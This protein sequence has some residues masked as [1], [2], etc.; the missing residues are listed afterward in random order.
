MT[1]RLFRTKNLDTLLES[2][3]EPEHQLRRSLGVVSLTALGIGAIIG[4][5]IFATTGSAAAGSAD[6]PGAGPAIIVS[7][8]VT[9]VACGFAALCYAEFASMLPISGSAYTYSYA[10]FGEL[11]AWVIGWDLILEYAVGNIAVAVS[12]SGY[13]DSLLSGLGVHLPP[14]AI[15]N[16]NTM[17]GAAA[18]G[19][20]KTP[21]MI[22]AARAAIDAA[23]HLLG[24]PVIVNIPAVVIVALITVVLVVG[25][26]ESAALNSTIVVLKI[27]VLI[28]FVV[29]GISYVDPGNW[30]PFAPNGWHGI[31]TGAA[32]VF[33]AYI[34]FDAVSTTAEEARNPQRDLPRSMMWSLAICTV[35]YIGIALVLTG[36]VPSS[37]LNVAD[38]LAFALHA[39]NL[40]WASGIIAFGAVISM[41]AVLLVFQLGQPRIFFSMSR[42]GLLPPAFSKVHPRF[43]TPHIPTILTGVFVAVP[44]A[45]LDINS[46]VEFTNIGTLFAFILVC[47]GVIILRRT[48]PDRQRRFRTPWVPLVPVLGILS[49]L[50]LMISLPGVTWLRFLIWLF[51]GANIYFLYGIDHS[52]LS[53][54]GT[55]GPD[56]SVRLIRW[57]VVVLDAAMLVFLFVILRSGNPTLATVF[58]YFF[59]ALLLVF[60]IGMVRKLLSAGPAAS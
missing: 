21:A 5:G 17:F 35:L 28:L 55:P 43:R 57:I 20:G 42:D 24:F 25:I 34:G 50:Y 16:Y 47:A 52:R 19:A 46:A 26:R 8:I 12:W 32:L 33:F 27:I 23:P 59:F 11:V 14:W 53:G 48:Q 30:T 41:T 60:L 36:L 38:P 13:F 54:G 9:A 10:S 4:A 3:E 37:L 15:S 44:A 2:S 29:I 6:H 40:D 22:E 49:C 7:F 18:E 51:V 39:H 56:G 45:F 58:E 31:M 1:H